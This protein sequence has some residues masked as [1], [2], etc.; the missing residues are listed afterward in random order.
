MSGELPSCIIQYPACGACGSD[1][2]HDGDSFYCD[3]C[4]LDFGP[5]DS[6]PATFRDEEQPA[7]GKECRNNWHKVY[8]LTCEECKLPEGHKSDCWTGCK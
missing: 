3:D 7:C 1:T 5:D 4:G 2:E 6:E 8:E